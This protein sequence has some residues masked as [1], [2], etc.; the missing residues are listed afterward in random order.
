LV[1][2]N[3]WQVRLCLLRDKTDSALF[4][5]VFN[6]VVVHANKIFYN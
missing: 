5:L 4:V 3:F 6:H 2:H 1:V